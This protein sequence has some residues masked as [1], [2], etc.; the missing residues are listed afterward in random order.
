MATEPFYA[1]DF[2]GGSY[3]YSAKGESAQ[4]SVNLY[5]EQIETQGGKTKF[6]LRSV[7]ALRAWKAFSGTCRGLYF[8]ASKGALWAVYGADVYRISGPDAQPV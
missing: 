7:K 1:D 2:V 3:D 6:C 4:R 5:T 8:D